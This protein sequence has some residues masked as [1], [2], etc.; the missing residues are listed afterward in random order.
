MGKSFAEIKEFK[1]GNLKNKFEN[2]KE[3]FELI[4]KDVGVQG[5]LV[6]EKVIEWDEDSVRKAEA[7]EGLRN[8]V[9]EFVKSNEKIKELQDYF[10][11]WK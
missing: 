7:V 11:D 1:N 6:G 8:Y 9:M 10:V 3:N 5:G 2:L 4:G